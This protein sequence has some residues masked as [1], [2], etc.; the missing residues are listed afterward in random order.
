MKYTLAIDQSTSATKLMLF[1]QHETLCSRVSLDHAQY[2]PQPGWVEHD[3]EEIMANIWK[4]IPLLVQQAG[5]AVADIASVALTNQRET[6]VVW[7]AATGKPLCHAVV[8]QCL[9]GADTCR[10]LREQGYGP[11]VQSKT[12]LLIDPYFAATG[13]KWILDNV[14]DA[15]RQADEG[16]LRMG[17]MDSWMI[18]NLTGGRVHATDRTNASRTML[19]NIHT[20]DW[21]ADL[22]DLL[23]VPASMMPAVKAC[24][25]VFGYTDLNGLLDREIPIAGVLGDSH[26]ALVGQMCFQE[27]MGKATYG[28]GSSVMVNIGPTA[29]EAPEGLVTSVGFSAQGKTWYAFEGNIHCTGATVKWM[30]DDLELLHNSKESEAVAT[31]VPDNGGVYF[32]PAFAGLGAPW[33]NSEA[34]ALVCG[35]SRGTKKAHVVRAALEAIAYQ[36]NDLVALMV[37]KAGVR[38][39]ELRADGGPAGNAFLMQFQADMLQAPVNVSPIEEA[40]A[41]G[42]V[43]M[44]ALALKRFDSLEALASLRKDNRLV[45]PAMPLADREALTAAWHQAVARAQL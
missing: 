11:L 31:S 8:W 24:D 7:N 45:R 1:D 19:F 12:G 34:R 26:G 20:L 21:D 22:L 17:T 44:N 37:D 32:V 4:G 2:Y 18:W 10:Q 9:R 43:L 23:T 16:L 13:V 39:R 14:P 3:A 30:V 38:L 35:M 27:G 25:E 40:S 6:V 15:R 41:L 29:A 5:I 33:W 28:T 42:A 36:V